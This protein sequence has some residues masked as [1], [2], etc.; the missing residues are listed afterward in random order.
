[1]SKK[2]EKRRQTKRTYVHRPNAVC[3]TIHSQDGS[4]VP[5]SVLS[6]ASDAV[7][8]IAQKYNLLINLA[9]S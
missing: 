8:E 7:W 1:M 2:N 4:P 5:R 9:D 6:E 3:I